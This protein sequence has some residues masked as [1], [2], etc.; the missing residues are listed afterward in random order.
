VAAG[1]LSKSRLKG[2]PVEDMDDVAHGL[3]VATKLG[4][5]LI[6]TLLSIGA[7]KQY[8]TA[9]QDEGIRRAQ[10]CLQTLA[11]G[12]TQRTRED[13]FSHTKEDKLLPIILLGYALRARNFETSPMLGVLPKSTS[14]ARKDR[15]VGLDKMCLLIEVRLSCV[16]GRSVPSE[17][18]GPG[19]KC[20]RGQ[21]L[22]IG[23]IRKIECTPLGG[24]PFA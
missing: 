3:G 2:I 19:A 6:G 20:P 18:R 12:V 14:P 1:A 22:S 4:S 21:K 8:L 16:L 10:S 11:L 17:G 9:A 5:D 15:K 23:T 7:G 24:S 13:R